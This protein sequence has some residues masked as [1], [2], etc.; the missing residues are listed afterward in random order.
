MAKAELDQWLTGVDTILD[1]PKVA[2]EPADVHKLHISKKVQTIATQVT[3]AARRPAPLPKWITGYNSAHKNPDRNEFVIQTAIRQYLE[4][5]NLLEEFRALTWRDVCPEEGTTVLVPG[6]TI[7]GSGVCM[8]LA[9][10]TFPLCAVRYYFVEYDYNDRGA[11]AFKMFAATRPLR[12]ISPAG[13][14]PAP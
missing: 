10:P 8:D 4:G 9:D 2:T 12:T 6:T 7:E 14:S 13:S 5:R 11:N 1:A 3:L